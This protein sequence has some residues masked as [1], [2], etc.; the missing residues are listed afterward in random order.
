[1]VDEH[2]RIERKRHVPDVVERENARAPRAARVPA[3]APSAAETGP[4]DPLTPDAVDVGYWGRLDTGHRKILLLTVAASVAALLLVAGGLWFVLTP[5]EEPGTGPP[6]HPSAIPTEPPTSTAE[7]TSSASGTAPVE[8]T[9][10]PAPAAPAG[11]APVI[12]YRAGGAIW[13]SGQRGANARTVYASASGVFSLSPD[14][15]TLAAIDGGSGNLSL[16]DVGSGA[17]LA[18]GQAVP[19]RPD[20]AADSSFLVY[21]RSTGQVT[22]VVTVRRNG[23]G[24]RVVAQGEFARLTPDGIALV[25]I[26]AGSLGTQPLSF[27]ALAGGQR[28][29]GPAG[30]PYSAVAPSSGGTF[31]GTYGFG[32]DA[33]GVRPA[34]VGFVRYDGKGLRTLVSRPAGGER[35]SFTDMCLSPDGRWLLYCETGDDGYS[36]VYSVPVDGGTPVSLTPRLDGYPLRFSADGTELF[37]VEGNAVQGEPTRVSAIRPDGGGHRIV[38][39]GG[40]F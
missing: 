8:P 12:A 32:T 21:V 40:G 28:K 31:F 4:I 35:V 25:V 11:R 27:V 23:T 17:V 19:S 13:V 24:Q 16:I 3:A 1:M 15:L 2:G 10:V 22:D 6:P 7:A 26:P 18:I 33:T 5:R 9:A 38:V 29:F 14:G 20:W 30:A 36:R 39:E 34:T 37:L